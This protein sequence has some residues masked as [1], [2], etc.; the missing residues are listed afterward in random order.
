MLYPW[1]TN[2]I[3]RRRGRKVC[4]FVPQTLAALG[5]VTEAHGKMPD[6]I[7]YFQERNW[8][9]L[10]EAVTSHGPIDAKRRAELQTLFQGTSAG[11]VFITAFLTRKAMNAY[12]GRLHGR[13]RFGWLKHRRISS[14]STATSFWGHM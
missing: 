5:V 3:C 14:T 11:L 8:L 9:V 13:Q 1:R 4:V 12:L 2:F 6:L 10:I 7:V